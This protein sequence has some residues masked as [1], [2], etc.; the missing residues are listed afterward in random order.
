MGWS[1]P[2]DSSSVNEIS[3]IRLAGAVD[4]MRRH[5]TAERV[6]AGITA[7][8]LLYTATQS[9][10]AR[11]WLGIGV[12]TALAAIA[13]AYERSRPLLYATAGAM[14]VALTTRETFSFW[15]AAAALL[16]LSARSSRRF[17]LTASLGALVGLVIAS[18]T[19]LAPALLPVTV[20]AVA[21]GAATAM[22]SLVRKAI[23]LEAEAASLRE[24][25]EISEEQ[26]RE[27]E[28]RTALARELHDVIGHHVTAM[29]VQADAGHVGSPGAALDAIGALGREALVELEVL[30]FG[31]RNPKADPATV[32]LDG[33]DSRLAPRL[34]AQGISVEVLVN[35]T[36]GG[37]DSVRSVYRIVQ[38]ATT[39]VMRHAKAS[40]V[41]VEVADRGMEVLVRVTDDGVGLPQH[42]SRGSG[43]AGIDERARRLGGSSAVYRAEPRGTVVEVRFPRSRP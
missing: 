15:P 7:A 8:A 9:P 41:S 27:L 38:E 5:V 12:I 23:R 10:G 20:A 22:S 24:R 29:V 31:L 42:L 17:P 21:A 2:P 4:V 28:R 14:A 33:I 36:E 13:A 34:R 43:L 37:S 16:F 11:E 18:F 26:T 6:A 32:D 19:E 40:N 3:R 39:N 1:L 25:A 35:T 30:L